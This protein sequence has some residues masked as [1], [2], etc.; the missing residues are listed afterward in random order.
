MSGAGLL[1]L[2]RS[3]NPM[4]RRTADMFLRNNTFSSS[5]EILRISMNRKFH[6]RAHNNPILVSILNPIKPVHTVHPISL[7]SIFIF[8]SHLCWG[9]RIDCFLV[10]FPTEIL[11]AF[12]LF[13]V[14]ATLSV[15]FMFLSFITLTVIGEEYNP[16]IFIIYFY[17][18]TCD[19]LH[20]RPSVFE[21]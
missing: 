17:L 3:L 5:Q 1:A 15:Y 12:L 2:A 20:L 21:L 18:S 14:R 13:F 10:D 4:L 8:T 19:I 11:Y 7:R 6:Y 16:P 9:F